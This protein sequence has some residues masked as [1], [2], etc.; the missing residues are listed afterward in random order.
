MTGD[1]FWLFRVVCRACRVACGLDLAD[2]ELY[3]VAMA[4]VSCMLPLK[5]IFGQALF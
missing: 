4:A 5:G 1:R 2:Y 3:I